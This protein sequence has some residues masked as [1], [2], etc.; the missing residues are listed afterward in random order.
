[1]RRTRLLRSFG[2]QL[3]RESDGH[4]AAVEGTAALYL[5]PRHWAGTARC[6]GRASTLDHIGYDQSQTLAPVSYLR[7]DGTLLRQS[8]FAPAP[9]FT[10]AQRGDRR[11]R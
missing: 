3:L 7:E 11:V 1:M 2:G 10:I 8:V 5:P 6:E 9:A 4:V